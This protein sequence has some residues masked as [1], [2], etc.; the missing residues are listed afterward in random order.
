MGSYPISKRLNCF[1]N[2]EYLLNPTFP[3]CP[4]CQ[5]SIIFDGCQ[6]LLVHTRSQ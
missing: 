4:V 5:C 3:Q 6:S 1:S 2:T